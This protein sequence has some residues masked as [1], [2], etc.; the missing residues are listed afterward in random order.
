MARVQTFLNSHDKKS[1]TG[2]IL[3]N[4]KI[5]TCKLQSIIREKKMNNFC[6]RKNTFE[7]NLHFVVLKRTLKSVFKIT[8]KSAVKF[9]TIVESK[10]CLTQRRLNY[11][12]E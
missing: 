1:R 8:S 12:R 4:S 7:V 3:E 2:K 10:T 9:L 11:T 6:R 5:I